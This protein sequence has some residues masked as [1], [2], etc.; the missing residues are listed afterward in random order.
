MVGI[1]GLHLVVEY[2]DPAT[3]V[4]L[5]ARGGAGAAV[6]ACQGLQLAAHL[7]LLWSNELVCLAIHSAEV[8]AI[9]GPAAVGHACVQVEEGV[10]DSV[11]HA[12]SRLHQGVEVLGERRHDSSLAEPAGHD[13]FVAVRLGATAQLCDGAGGSGGIENAFAFSGNL[14]TV[15]E[16]SAVVLND[17]GDE[18]AAGHARNSR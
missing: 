12:P 1:A 5:Q 7:G 11:A 2:D 16:L 4:A 6:E 8:L 10:A 14:R 9:Q 3:A 18:A 17:G 13:P 15:S